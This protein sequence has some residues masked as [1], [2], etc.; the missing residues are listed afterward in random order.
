VLG[1]ANLLADGFIM[2]GSN[3]RSTRV[4]HEFVAEL[5]RIEA[6]QIN[7]VPDGEREGIR[8]IYEVKGF[9]GN[10]RERIIDVI[11]ADRRRWTDTMLLQDH[12]VQLD[13]PDPLRAAL[14]IFVEVLVIGSIPLFS[15]LADAIP[16]GAITNPF[17]WSEE[18]TTVALSPSV[19]SKRMHSSSS[20]SVA[21]QRHCQ[22]PSAICCEG[23]DSA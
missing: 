11:T 8:Q 17:W 6:E 16:D 21:Q 5:R 3:F 19:M 18:L 20:S 1:L 15:L 12:R 22:E 4:D 9:R 10:D 7:E 13:G 23:W 2:A 14:A